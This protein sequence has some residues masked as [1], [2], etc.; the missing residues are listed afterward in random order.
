MAAHDAHA[1]VRQT[2][3]PDLEVDGA[4]AIWIDRGTITVP[5]DLDDRTPGP[6]GWQLPASTQW[7]LLWSPTAAIRVEDSHL[8]AP[9]LCVIELRVQESGLGADQ[10]ARNPAAAQHLALELAERWQRSVPEML[11][12][13]VLLAR[14]S[15]GVLTVLTGV[16]LG[17]V[18]DDLYAQEARQEDFGARLDGRRIR[19]AVWAPTA[20]R[21]SLLTWPEQAGNNPPLDRADRRQMMRT[22]SGTWKGGIDADLVGARYLYEVVVY[23]PVTRRMETNLVTDPYAAGLT[24]DSRHSVIVDLADPAWTPENW[25]E[26]AGPRLH[27]LVDAAVYELHVRDF[28]ASDESVPE[29]LR[30]SYLA[31]T[32]DGNGTRHLRR[33]ARSGLNSVHLLPCF[34][35]TS[36]PEHGAA[37]QPDQSLLASFP[38]D[39][40][41]QQRLIARTASH[42]AFNWGYDPWHWGVPEGSYASTPE[43]ADGAHRV[44]EFRCMVQALHGLGLRVVLD[45]VFTH[46]SASG[47][48][49]HS[50]LDRIVPGY[51]HRLD[52]TGSTEGSAAGNNVAT[53]RL[54]TE[55][56]MVDMVVR[57]ARDYH[58][59]GFRFD[60]MGHS[61]TRNM[62]RVRHALDELTL[63]RDGVDGQDVYLYGEGWNFGE[64]ADNA[65]FT[66]AVQGQ[67][68][69]TGIGT[70]N[71][72]LRDAVRGGRPFDEDPRRQ[73]FGSGLAGD[74]NG[75]P[76]NRE[77]ERQLAHDTD[78][79][80]LG[81]AGNLRD[82]EL[83]CTDGVIRRGDEIDYNGRPAG[84]A[85]EPSDVINYVDAHDNET[86]WDALTMKLPPELDMAARIRMNTLCLAT[87]ALGQAPFLWHAGTDLLR[88]KSLDRNS[89]NSGDWFNRLDWTG[90]DNGFGHGLPPADD[91]MTRWP[92][93]RPLLA[94]PSLKPSAKDVELASEQARTLLK[95]RRSTPLFR[96]GS[97]ELIRQKVTFPLSGTPGAVP[98]VILMH[99]DDRT[100]PIDPDL[101][102]LVVVFNATP[103]PVR[104][105]LPEVSGQKV[106]LSP[107]HCKGTDRST[108]E[109]RFDHMGF[110]VPA[111]TVA[112]FNHLR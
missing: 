103:H 106:V 37:A 7:L 107:L 43:M 104:Q 95:L 97:A 110:E 68:E 2:C 96:L 55:K 87:V 80:M 70:F 91:N 39:S 74:H 14:R 111:R 60:L 35:L 29:H 71:D 62:A 41:E 88:S 31:F 94:D 105:V 112:V 63:D 10:A 45:Q 53:E 54:M 11:T 58:I 15:Q 79:V 24:V 13:Q 90:R 33:L 48:D 3:S 57:W 34:D 89:Y 66:Q 65:L 50:V 38:P 76:C 47:Q 67:L 42:D 72:R 36:V 73:G 16:Q 52:A 20:Q 82:F 69:G 61:S 21:V 22:A 92:W 17:P 32:T 81:L 8:W 84:Y 78:L 100:D 101:A 98:G 12:G 109:S 4:R 51:H 5:L 28:S 83:Q 27:G 1:D 56:L 9:D 108:C 19:F 93:L 40:H 59:D 64:V 102:G 49:P 86:L 85:A 99:I 26:S 25:A 46:T 6:H 44:K 77:P 75:A 23:S 18:L 30:G